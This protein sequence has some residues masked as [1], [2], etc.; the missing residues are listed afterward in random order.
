MIELHFPTS[1]LC[2]R[3]TGVWNIVN[4]SGYTGPTVT[5]TAPMKSRELVGAMLTLRSMFSI[6]EWKSNQKPSPPPSEFSK[7]M[8]DWMGFGL[9]HK[10][11]YPSPVN[12]S[13]F[14]YDD[15]DVDNP[16]E[17]IQSMLLL[18]TPEVSPLFALPKTL[19]VAK[20]ASLPL[21][22]YDEDGNV[23]EAIN[24]AW[25]EHA[26]PY[27]FTYYTD[28]PVDASRLAQIVCVLVNKVC[29]V[30]PTSMLA[31]VHES[32]FK[33]HPESEVP[34]DFSS[35]KTRLFYYLNVPEE[36]ATP[37]VTPT[38]EEKEAV[39]E[40]IIAQDIVMNL[41]DGTPIECGGAVRVT[42]YCGDMASFLKSG[43]RAYTEFTSNFKGKRLSKYALDFYN[44]LF[45]GDMDCGSGA[46][47]SSVK[48]Q[49]SC[50]HGDYV[51]T[52]AAFR[53]MYGSEHAHSKELRISKAIA[54][55]YED[56]NVSLTDAYAEQLL[57]SLLT[58]FYPVNEGTAQVYYATHELPDEYA[59]YTGDITIADP[60]T[61]HVCKYHGDGIWECSKVEKYAPGV[62]NR[63][64][65][66]V[67]AV[68]GDG[69][70]K[71]R[72]YAT[73]LATAV[74]AAE[75][76][77]RVRYEM[78]EDISKQSIFGSYDVLHT[79]SIE[80]SYI[81]DQWAEI[82]SDY[83]T[84]DVVVKTKGGAFL[85]NNGVWSLVPGYS[86]RELTSRLP[87]KAGT[88]CYMQGSTD[89]TKEVAEVISE[90]IATFIDTSKPEVQVS[91]EL[92]SA[93]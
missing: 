6:A 14:S 45:S 23:V 48:L 42:N 82:H 63:R 2:L 5:A 59:R 3:Y 77:A 91:L 50:E 12:G 71:S 25:E 58:H 73:I 19:L 57:A 79:C 80:S 93:L 47:D 21:E 8:P 16:V 84:C 39:V 46:P 86:N 54:I 10:N 4:E 37:D 31:G 40:Q 61:M 29:S 7:S 51:W 81:G 15:V 38:V 36:F 33:A 24:P 27:G 52:G 72:E 28:G 13:W 11:R 62:S 17:A 87:V 18:A 78:R 49:V 88:V 55:R 67:V 92:E 65:G 70:L 22:A 35:N 44:E 26:T 53:K 34:F 75:K 56:A 43:V 32:V 83:T 89:F 30:Y 66:L 76:L 60:R 41:S 20:A 85:Y 9:E 69:W 64:T 68:D 90:F 74:A 1:G